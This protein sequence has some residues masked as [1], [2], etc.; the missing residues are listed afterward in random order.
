MQSIIWREK[1]TVRF[2]SVFTNEPELANWRALAPTFLIPHS[3]SGG[4]S[5]GNQESRGK[6]RQLASSNLKEKS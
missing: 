3:L 6:G 5:A 2:Q 4:G 1:M